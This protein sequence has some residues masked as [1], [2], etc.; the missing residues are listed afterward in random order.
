MMNSYISPYT[1]L[2]RGTLGAVRTVSCVCTLV[3]WDRIRLCMIFR[4][5]LLFSENKNQVISKVPNK[6]DLSIYNNGTNKCT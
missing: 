2:V 3:I 4:P 6:F 1:G 5:M